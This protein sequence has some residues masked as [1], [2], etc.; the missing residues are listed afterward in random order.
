MHE[1]IEHHLRLALVFSSRNPHLRFRQLENRDGVAEVSD[2]TAPADDPLDES[3]RRLLGGFASFN[4]I[5]TT[6][7]NS[8]VNASC[9]TDSGETAAESS[10]L[11]ADSPNPVADRVVGTLRRRSSVDEDTILLTTGVTAANYGGGDLGADES[12]SNA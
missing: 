8:S 4:A 3:M 1:K 10:A 2:S 11:L 9:E 5:N 7:S 12:N 6:N